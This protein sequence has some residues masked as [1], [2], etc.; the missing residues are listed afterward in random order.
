LHSLEEDV[1]QLYDARADFSLSNDLSAEHPE[2]LREL[3][4][5]FREEAIKN[6][7]YPLDDRSYERFNA[8]QA[9]RPDLMGGRTTLVLSDGM[10]GIMENAFINVKNKLVP[11]GEV[12]K[13]PR[14]A[15]PNPGVLNTPDK[16]YAM[17]T[18]LG[19]TAAQWRSKATDRKAIAQIAGQ[20]MRA[21]AWASKGDGIRS[22][23]EYIA[24][25]VSTYTSN[26][27]SIT[28]V[29]AKGVWKNGMWLL[30]IKRKMDTGHPDDVVFVKGK[31]VKAGIGIFN[32]SETDDHTISETLIFQF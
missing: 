2:K 9:G 16:A 29:K 32:H 20:F 17:I 24:V 28:D 6:N 13:D 19:E 3:K 4:A 22:N 31:A 23:H 11:P 12:L 7:V 1:W 26:E 10:T 8:K 25:G 30:E 5:L 21:V 14:G 15:L 27:G 18:G